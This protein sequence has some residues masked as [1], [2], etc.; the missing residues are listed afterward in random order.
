MTI[1]SLSQ[2]RAEIQRLVRRREPNDPELVEVLLAE[3]RLIDEKTRAEALQDPGI[4]LADRLRFGSPLE[5]DEKRV[6]REGGFSL[7]PLEGVDP[8]IET[9]RRV[10]RL[11]I[12][13]LTI[14][15]ASALLQ[16]S[17]ERVLELCRGRHIYSL[18]SAYGLTRFPRFQFNED[19]LLPGFES[20][21]PHI[22]EEEYLV[23]VTNWFTLPNPDLYLKDDVDDTLS[24]RDWLL[25]GYDP[26]MVIALLQLP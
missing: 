19:G 26:K 10:A 3:Q 21:A 18:N 4:P 7:A 12:E 15:E 6:L 22:L 1:D 20:V 5:D 16:I 8:L 23:E 24:P 17:V 9:Q 11:L 2:A 25:G 13:S 14:D